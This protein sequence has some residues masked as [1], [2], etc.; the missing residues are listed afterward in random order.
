MFQINYHCAI[1]KILSGSDVKK[2]AQYIID[3]NK[4]EY[5]NKITFHKNHRKRQISNEKNICRW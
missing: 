5:K 2:H 4:M 1:W 3:V